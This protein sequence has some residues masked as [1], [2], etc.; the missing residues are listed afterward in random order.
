[1]LLSWAEFLS[2]CS[3]RL[4]A[5]RCFGIGGTPALRTADGHLTKVLVN[6][7]P[8]KM[9]VLQAIVRC[10]IQDARCFLRTF[11][12]TAWVTKT[13]APTIRYVLGHQLDMDQSQILPMES[14]PGGAPPIG[15]SLSW[16]PL[17][18]PSITVCSPRGATSD[19]VGKTI[20]GLKAASLGPCLPL[21]GNSWPRP[22]KPFHHNQLVVG[23]FGHQTHPVSNWMGLSLWWYLPAIR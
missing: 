21:G 7:F 18:L 4:G 19:G 12:L 16:P 23:E 17:S 15:V 8:W 11:F 5:S 14:H 3:G 10:E 20:G 13:E 1:M 9:H 6:S 2:C 22:L